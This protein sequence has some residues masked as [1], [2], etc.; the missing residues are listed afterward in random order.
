MIMSH[1]DVVVASGDWVEPPFSGTIKDGKLWGRGTVDTKTPLYSEL[2]AVEELLEKE[3]IPEVNIYIASSNNEEIGGNGIPLAVEHFK[4]EG[5]KFELVVDEGGAIINAPVPGMKAKAAMIAVHEKGRKTLKCTAT[6][7]FGHFGLSPKSDTPIV[8]MAKFI[9]EVDR[10][11]PFIKKIH[12]EVLAM[13]KDLCPYMNMP[14]RIVF[15]NL[16][17]FGP[18]LKILLSKINPQG[19]TM[20]GTMCYFTSINGGKEK[21]VQTKEVE[22]TAFLRCVNDEDLKNDIEEIKKIANKYSIIIEEDEG[23]YY[24]PTNLKMPAYDYVKRTVNEVFPSVAVAPYILPAGSDSRHMTEV[25]SCTLRFAP[26]D[27]T[28]EQFSSVHNNNE[29]INID[30]IGNSVTFYKILVENYK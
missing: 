9:E 6:T 7:E 20:L 21:Q 18:L 27:I 4:R 15:A 16:W 12:L 19:G 11:K 2:K 22:A 25:C 3:F 5:I 26:I 1:H 8:R 23:E 17:L 28:P 14:F 30:I 10:K 24:K 13:F 29:N